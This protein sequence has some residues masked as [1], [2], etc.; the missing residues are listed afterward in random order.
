MI[1]DQMKYKNIN[2]NDYNSLSKLKMMNNSNSK[3]VVKLNN[4]N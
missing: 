4:Y 3:S 1:L 2:S